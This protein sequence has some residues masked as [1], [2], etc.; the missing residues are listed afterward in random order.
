MN[1][2]ATYS[3]EDDK[4]R[5]YP[6]Y[7]LPKEEY[8][9]LKSTGYSWA[10]KQECFYAVWSPTRE[11]V[12]LDFADEIEDEDKSLVDRAEE[13]ADRFET[14]SDNRAKD[15]ERAHAAVK[16]IADNIPLGQPILVGHHSEKRARRDAQRI[17]RGMQK[18]VD[19]WETSEYWTQRAAGALAH[20]KYKERPDVR[21]RRIKG[22][23]ADKR[24]QEKYQ[25]EATQELAAWEKVQTIEEGRKLAGYSQ[26]GRLPCVKHPKFSHYRSAYDVLQ[27]QEEQYQD[28]E[29]W[30]LDQVKER[31]RV[32]YPRQIARA[33][34]WLDHINNRLAYERAMLAEGGGLQAD[35][36]NI[37]VGGQVLSKWGW[38]VVL[39]VNKKAGVMTSV[40]V[41]GIS[42]T[43]KTEDIKDYKE[44]KEG[45]AEKVQAATKLPP[46][47][48]YKTE[49]CATMTQAEFTATYKDHKGSMIVKATETHGAHR[50]RTIQ[51]F[52][53]RRHGAV[54][55]DQW[56]NTPVFISDAKVTDPPALTV[57]APV[58]LPQVER[59]A[60]QPA[61]QP[62]EKSEAERKADE[63]KQA[64]KTGVQVVSA[65]QLFPTPPE[66][67]A[68]MVEIA[69]IKPGMNVL[70]P[71]AG[72][73]NILKALPCVRPNGW[74]M[75]IEIKSQLAKLLESEADEVHNGDFLQLKADDIGLFD[76]IVMNPPFE[77]G[78]DIKHIKHALTMLKPGGTL[79][80]ICAGGPR[81]EKELEPLADLWEPLP[82]GTFKGQ[83][84]NVNTVLLTIIKPE[85]V[86]AN[87][88]SLV[89]AVLTQLSLF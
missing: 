14:Y 29:A 43:L 62:R 65:P 12:A 88:P 21:A 5:I 82:A 60:P 80:A 54:N 20:A 25:Q 85:A 34:V 7:R 17:E 56:G 46:M 67:C 52:L 61:Y 27:P 79:V 48:N 69:D 30:T 6:A 22:L 26:A 4:I 3:P 36:F 75:A 59:E 41:T 24:K 57:A 63:L 23:E 86:K 15:A 40:S 32:Y 77:N 74:V 33:Q 84:T 9:Q 51:N 1:H 72:T 38:H 66:L 71:S 64:L 47:C 76:R 78:S 49:S 58:S 89:K 53:A 55:A 13:R 50:R 18:A 87:P 45:D 73:G 83:G 70:E 28:C 11:D 81:Q 68:R 16:S 31:A 44:P 42:W 35:K 37:V 19:A 10:P 8:D 39:K 2:T